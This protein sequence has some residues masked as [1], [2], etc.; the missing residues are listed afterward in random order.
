MKRKINTI[1]LFA[2]CGGLLDGFLQEGNYNSLAC[3]EWEKYPCLTLA[4]RLQKKWNHINADNEVI[5]FDI[6]RTQ[7]LFDGFEDE[8]YG[9]HIGLDKLIGKKKMHTFFS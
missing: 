1:D 4:N 2:G 7:E 9:T 6:Q 8:E 5:R 3:V